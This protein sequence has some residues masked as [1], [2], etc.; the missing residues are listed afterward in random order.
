MELKQRFRR[1]SLPHST[2]IAIAGR[3][4]NNRLLQKV[5]WLNHGGGINRGLLAGRE[6]CEFL[7]DELSSEGTRLVSTNTEQ[8]KTCENHWFDGQAW[9]ACD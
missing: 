5:R 9:T 1:E 3:R 4:W 6:S 8:R 7:A 2:I